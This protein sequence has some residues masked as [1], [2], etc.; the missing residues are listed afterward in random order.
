MKS[1]RTRMLSLL[2][3]M[4]LTSSLLLSACGGGTAP[5]P[6][7][8][9]TDA[10]VASGS[11]DSSGS[12]PAQ[13][14]AKTVTMAMTSNWDS[15]IPHDTTSNYSDVIINQI[16]E[17]LA[18]IRHDGSFT[19]GL[20]LSW[21][22]NEDNTVFTF[23][24]DK[25][26]KWHDG[27]PVTADDVV[28]TARVMSNA[29]VP[30]ARRS[31]RYFAGTDDSGLEL[32]ANSI[33]VEALD[34]HTV[35]FH[36]KESMDPDY[37]LAIFNRDFYI[38]PA[39]VFEGVAMADINKSAFW[40][41]P[42]IGSGAFIYDNAISG[43]RVELVAN[44]DFHLG[45]PK[46][47]R[48]V[49][50][51]VGA[52][53]Q[54]AGL[55]SGDIDILSDGS[56]S[57]QDWDLAQAQENLVCASMPSLGYQYMTCNTSKPYM[58]QKIRQAIDLAV[59][60]DVIINQ[61]L[62]GE[63]EAATGPLPQ[64]HLY[65]NKELLP[66]EYNLD[67]AAQMVKEEGWDESR[68]LLLIVPQ[69]N[70]VREKSAPLIQQDLARI[71]IKTRIRTMDFPTL[72]NMLREGEYDLGLLGSAGSLDPGESVFNVTVGH[73]NNFAHLTDPTLGNL[74]RDGSQ[75]TSFETRKPIYDEY[76]RVLNEQMPFVWLYFANK[77]MAYNNRLSNV[78]VEDFAFMNWCTWEWE[79]A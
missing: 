75:E 21:E 7:S 48:L 61:L 15:L 31:T 40:Q 47:D 77:L 46:F 44:P 34:E 24:L 33:G 20:A 62:K 36:L 63:G 9:G 54:M 69:G 4:A 73:A 60:R 49:I 50:K 28:F 74:G 32:S 30:A 79:V 66:I 38:I 12:A 56:I 53:N 23:H 41:N 37:F 76:Q 57:L 72:M 26:A 42:I 71:G 16:F 67:K 51:V 3:V 19:P 70:Q 27:Q 65:F 6:S 14:G 68:E 25:K 43:E 78:P 10:P 2:L 17:K 18:T 59:N 8:G 35:A 11:S 58:T 45:A 55:M 29:D 5:P 64:S 1:R 52:Q 13:E 39:H 22:M